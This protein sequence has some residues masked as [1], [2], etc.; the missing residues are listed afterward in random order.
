MD[1]SWGHT[2]GVVLYIKYLKLEAGARWL[3][4]PVAKRLLSTKGKSQAI[5]PDTYLPCALL[6]W[7]RLPEN[8]ESVTKT[9]VSPLNPPLSILI[10]CK[11]REHKSLD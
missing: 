2:W 7:I 9:I 3:Q 8:T 11:T 1:C 6:E 10:I 5:E 4:K